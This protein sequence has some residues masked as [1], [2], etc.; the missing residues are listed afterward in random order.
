MAHPRAIAFTE[1]TL[2][3]KFEAHLKRVR[4]KSFMWKLASIE[5]ARKLIQ[6]HEYSIDIEGWLEYP[7]MYHHGANRFREISQAQPL[8]SLPQNWNLTHA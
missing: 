8:S 1:R 3:F 7:V 4:A 2:A 5:R 6:R